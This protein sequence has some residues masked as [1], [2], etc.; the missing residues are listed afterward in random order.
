[1]RG[2]SDPIDA[3]AAARAVLAGNASVAKESDDLVAMIRSLRLARRSALK[4]R[5]QAS[6]QIRAL[7]VTAPADL[8]ERCAA[9]PSPS[10]WP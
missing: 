2:K 6:N 5:T 4:M 10:W 7:L 3:E 1:M 9:F 8:R